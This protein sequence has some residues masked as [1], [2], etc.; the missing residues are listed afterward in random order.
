MIKEGLVEQL[1]SVQRF[2]LNTVGCLDDGDSGFAPRSG[3]FTVA[4]Q[5]A[6]V[7][8]TVDWFVE[9]AFRPEGF[10][11][12]FETHMREAFRQRS[13]KEGLELFDRSMNNAVSVIGAKSDAELTVPLPSGPVMGGAPRLAIVGGIADH[14]AH[15]RGSL[16]VYA[17]LL[18]KEPKMPYG[19]A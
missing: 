7:A 8:Q 13:L 16:A 17:R 10:D 19:E 14:T 5:V 1:R 2:F 12:D 15:H 6:H 4:Q 11:L 18:G 3:M 9:G